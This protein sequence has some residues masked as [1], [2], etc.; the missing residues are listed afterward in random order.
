MSTVTE[1]VL[2]RGPEFY[3]RFIEGRDMEPAARKLPGGAGQKEYPPNPSTW[4]PD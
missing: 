1:T 4:L 2:R 3:D